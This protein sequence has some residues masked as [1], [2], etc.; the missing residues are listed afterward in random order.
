[1][2]IEKAKLAAYDTGFRVLIK[3]GL[4]AGKP[5]YK[6]FVME[7][8]STRGSETYGWSDTFPQL[9]EWIGEREV[10]SLDTHSFT[11]KNKSF[12]GTV[13]IK[14]SDLEDDEVGLFNVGLTSMGMQAAVHPDKLCFELLNNGF[15]NLCYDGKAFFATDHP[16]KEGQ[17]SNKGVKKF[18]ATSYKAARANLRARTDR[19][20]NKLDIQLG[21]ENTFL[22]VNVG[23]EDKA[24]ELLTAEQISGT[25]NTMR[26]TATLIV[27]SRVDDGKWFLL[28][29]HM[30]LRSLVWQKRRD[31]RITIKGSPSDELVFWEGKAVYG[32]DYRGN[33]GYGLP[34][35]AYGSTGAED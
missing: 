24:R 9:R 30:G 25:T 19:Q 21:P 20:G 28:V 34:E 13:A 23:D 7:T 17:W 35:F 31:P 29:D 14:E 33:A 22:I 12:E 1:M 2:P 8:I 32:V 27:S 26:N 15:T 3:N 10:L 4:A 18:S 11:I 5:V 16:K 6:S